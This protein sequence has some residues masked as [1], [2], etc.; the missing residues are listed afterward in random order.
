MKYVIDFEEEPF[1]NSKGTKLY[2]I[3]GSTSVCVPGPYLN[4]FPKYE[5]SPTANDDKR[6]KELKTLQPGDIIIRQNQA[7]AIV[8]QLVLYR[9]DTTDPTYQLISQLTG[10]IAVSSADELY[11]DGWQKYWNDY[12]TKD[13]FYYLR[14]N[15]SDLKGE[16][17]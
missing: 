11:S 2:R 5:E 4:H 16:K 9:Y 8:R 14:K 13:F 15:G 17:A 10:T 6:K 7:S 3:A 1:T 12:E